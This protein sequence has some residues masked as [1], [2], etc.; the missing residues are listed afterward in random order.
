M[1]QQRS[2]Q[3][4]AQT[5]DPES[6]SKECAYSGSGA[7]MS[8]S[9]HDRGNATALAA[10][11]IQSPGGDEGAQSLDALLSLYLGLAS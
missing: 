1:E 10:G 9:L 4:P 11:A 8:P 6:Y 5:P 7:L 2:F 3:Q